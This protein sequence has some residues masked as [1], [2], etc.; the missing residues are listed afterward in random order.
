M[1]DTGFV[2]RINVNPDEKK[3]DRVTFFLE[4]LCK[5]CGGGGSMLITSCDRKSKGLCILQYRSKNGA[6]LNSK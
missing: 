2:F 6:M 4:S 5:I 1:H 3:H